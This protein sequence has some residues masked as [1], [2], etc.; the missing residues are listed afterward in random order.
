MWELVNDGSLSQTVIQKL[1]RLRKSQRF[2]GPP[3]KDGKQSI[4][5]LTEYHLLRSQMRA[6]QDSRESS[7][8][9]AIL[10]LELPLRSIEKEFRRTCPT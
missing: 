3:R 4:P 5:P 10:P 1:D 7:P 2:L 9:I 8:T 6:G